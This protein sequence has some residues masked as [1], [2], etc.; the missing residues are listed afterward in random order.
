MFSSYIDS[1]N[2]LCTDFRFEKEEQRIPLGDRQ[3]ALSLLLEL[4]LQRGTLHHLLDCILLLLHLSDKASRSNELLKTGMDKELLPEEELNY[5][6]VPF[7]RKIANIP[8]TCN[9]STTKT[10]SL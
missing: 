8:S 3:K 9:Y 10:V 6:L 5:P 4:A 1:S 2:E 7:L